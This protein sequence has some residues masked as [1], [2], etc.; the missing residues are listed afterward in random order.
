MET[1]SWIRID[2]QVPRKSPGISLTGSQDHWTP[3]RAHP[4]DPLKSD[5]ISNLV[6]AGVIHNQLYGLF[7]VIDCHH[8][9]AAVFDYYGY[10]SDATGSVTDLVQIYGQSNVCH[11]LL[12]LARRIYKRLPGGALRR[13]ALASCDG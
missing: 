1:D 5:P 3:E 13:T 6:H 8:S 12:L 2:A 7:R 9:I 10:R 11:S 4:Q